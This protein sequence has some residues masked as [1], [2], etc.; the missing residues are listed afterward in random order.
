MGLTEG[1]GVEPCVM[2]TQPLRCNKENLICVFGE[3]DVGHFGGSVGPFS[4]FL[5]RRELKQ[6]LKSYMAPCFPPWRELNSDSQGYCCL[7]KM[8]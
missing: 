6:M 3:A 8:S 7:V 5:S 4:S 2:R 1:L